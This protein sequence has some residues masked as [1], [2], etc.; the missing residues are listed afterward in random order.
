VV[1]AIDERIFS[2]GLYPIDQAARLA[3]VSPRILRRWFDSDE[4]A[5]RRRLAKNDSDL[6]SFIDL[7]Q[8]LAIRALRKKKKLSLQRV[9]QTIIE[10]E[11]MGVTHPFARKHQTYLFDDDVV[12]AFPDGRIVGCTGEYR[13]Q[14][15]FKPIIELYLDD[16]GFDPKSGLASRYTPL[17]DNGFSIV[18]DPSIK[19][20]APIVH[21]IGYTVSSLVAA[22]DSEGSIEDAA[23]AYDV[24]PSVVKFALRYDD[25]LVETVN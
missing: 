2:E 12:L 4:P 19:Y 15:L 3:R 7:V 14:H 9:R 17:K 6:V 5:M 20:G 8:S 23:K 13:G 16:L 18:I 24:D 11:K 21:P 1:A 10:A 25:Y 22:V